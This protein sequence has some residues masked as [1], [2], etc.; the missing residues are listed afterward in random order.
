MSSPPPTLL[1]V[2]EPPPEEK[3]TRKGG[4]C[5]WFPFGVSCFEFVY[6]YK[7]PP[8]EA[9]VCREPKLKVHYSECVVL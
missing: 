7:A 4:G 9:K 1:L 3:G 8:V 5:A 6:I 2:S